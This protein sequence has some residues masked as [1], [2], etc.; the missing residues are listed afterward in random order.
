MTYAD[1]PIVYN[2]ITFMVDPFYFCHNSQRFRDIFH[3]GYSGFSQ[4]TIN[5]NFQPL[6]VDLFC[7]I[8]QNQQVT[9]PQECV[10]DIATL[11]RIFVAEP[12]VSNYIGNVTANPNG[13]IIFENRRS[14]NQAYDDFDW[15]NNYGYEEAASTQNTNFNFE[16]QYINAI[17]NPPPEQ[18]PSFEN[19]LPTNQFQDQSFGSNQY[20]EQNQTFGTNQFQEQNQTF[21]TSQFQEQDQTYGTSQF[22]D[23]NQFQDLLE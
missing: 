14:I 10:N 12:A 7:S 8:C 19:T 4:V 13:S 20:Q 18:P 6:S 1:F 2:G 21:G 23:Q 3:P 22:Q 9:V 5:G 17:A 11:A 15:L 16:N